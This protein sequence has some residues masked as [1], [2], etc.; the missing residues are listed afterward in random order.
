MIRST[1][2]VDIGSD[3]AHL[4][5]A[6]LASGRVDRVIAVEIADV[7]AANSRRTL[8]GM[9]ADVRSGDGFDV[10]GMG[11]ADT[12][13]VCGMGGRT[14]TDILIRGGDRLPPTLVLQ[15]NRDV[16]MV[17]RVAIGLGYAIIDEA[18]VATSSAGRYFEVIQFGRDGVG[19]LAQMQLDD[20]DWYYGPLLI[21]RRDAVVLDRMRWD[22]D[23]LD[24]RRHL[25]VA[26]QKRLAALITFLDGLDA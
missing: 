18:I 13:S 24:R 7:P 20:F 22:R 1:T 2:H 11:E 6:L 17:R 3:H 19:A 9:N 5:A 23:Y 15:P 26:E 4:P 10:V 14:M 25:N 12:A 16:A 8:A 21:E